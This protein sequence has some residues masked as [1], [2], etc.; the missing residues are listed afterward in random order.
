MC[1]YLT[2]FALSILCFFCAER[3]SDRYK[4]VF[5]VF[6]IFPPAIIAGCRDIAI[7]TDTS[8]YPYSTFLTC[9]HSHHVMRAFRYVNEDLESLYVILAYISSVFVS[10]FNSF[11]FVCHVI[12]L[13][14]MAYSSI[15]P[16]CNLFI[17]RQFLASVNIR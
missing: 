9:C 8:A 4:C 14:T 15:E 5:Y 1:P 10:K 6:A 12:I 13:G 16:F 17:M 7:G 3:L 11:L 2:A